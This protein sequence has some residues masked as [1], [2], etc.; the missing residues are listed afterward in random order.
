MAW[1]II[2]IF[3]FPPFLSFS[4]RKKNSVCNLWPQN[5][6]NEKA[7]LPGLLPHLHSRCWPWGGQHSSGLGQGP[8]YHQGRPLAK[9]E[10]ASEKTSQGD[11]REKSLS[12]DSKPYGIFSLLKPETTLCWSKK[13]K[14]GYKVCMCVSFG[15]HNTLFFS[16]YWA[17]D[18]LL[19]Y[20]VWCHLRHLSNR[21]EP[22]FINSG[23][24]NICGR[25][26][27]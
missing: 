9:K 27:Y 19:A 16:V 1:I 13:K 26:K 11:K 14:M 2:K 23:I 12:R 5:N 10:T 20:S 6:N 15:L 7:L 22:H 18:V 8:S 4:S 17:Q 3:C 21:G 24:W 25:V